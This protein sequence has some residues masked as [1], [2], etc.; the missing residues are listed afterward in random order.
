MRAKI[1]HRIIKSSGTCD[2]SNTEHVITPTYRYFLGSKDICVFLA[3]LQFWQNACILN[4][5]QFDA[6][7]G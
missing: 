7:V 3:Y 5:S 2:Y 4:K 6:N 1:G